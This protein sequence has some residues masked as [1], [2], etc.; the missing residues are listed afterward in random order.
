M[1]APFTKQESAWLRG[2]ALTGT[3]AAM[4]TPVLAV[5]WMSPPAVFEGEEPAQPV[6]FAHRDHTG[7]DRIPCRYCHRSVEHAPRAGMPSAEVCMHC[8]A[9]IQREAPELAEVRRAA[10]EQRPILWQRR[11]A[12]PG[13]VSFSHATHVRTNISCDTC[14]GAA[15][16]GEVVEH[17]PP[18]FRMAWCVACHQEAH[19]KTNREAHRQDADR[20]GAAARGSYPDST[21]P[22]HCSGC[23]R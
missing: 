4:S 10:L 21:A 15:L 17:R 18:L 11:N 19:R 13:N 5:V 16:D 2:S 6:P 1:P 9:Q 8:H 14:H 7:A 23:H 22:L 3:L 20:R 12:L